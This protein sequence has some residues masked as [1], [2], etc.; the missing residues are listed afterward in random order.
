MDPSSSQKGFRK[1]WR[2]AAARSSSLLADRVLSELES[3]Q[4]LDEEAFRAGASVASF[5][6]SESD[7]KR[8]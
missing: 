4:A 8:S 5:G 3:E 7:A 6:I 2:E 1:R